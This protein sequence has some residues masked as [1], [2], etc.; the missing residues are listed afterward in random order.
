MFKKTKTTLLIII[1][2]VIVVTMAINLYM[3]T[4]TGKA[5]INSEIEKKTEAISTLNSNIIESYVAQTI[6]KDSS[7]ANFVALTYTQK[8]IDLYERVLIN[9]LESNGAAY[10]HFIAFEPYI[11]DESKEFVGPYVSLVNGEATISYDYSTSYYNYTNQEFYQ[12]TKE[13]RKPYISNAIYDD[14]SNKYMITVSTPIIDRQNNFIGCVSTDI[15]LTYLSVLIDRYN[16]NDSQMYIVDSEGNY[17][18]HSDFSKVKNGDNILN[19]IDPSFSNTAME[20]AKSEKGS[21]IYTEYGKDYVVYYNTLEDLGWKLI[22]V[23]D[24]ATINAPITLLKNK[25]IVISLISILL[26]S[27]SIIIII[28][29]RVE[30][31]IEMLLWEFDKI[32]KNIYSASIPENVLIRKDEFGIL[33]NSLA[34]MKTKL[35]DYQLDLEESLLQNVEF[36]EEAKLQNECLLQSESH[37]RDAINYIDSIFSAI[38]NLIYVFDKDGL[39]IDNRGTDS[40]NFASDQTLVGT[41]IL[42]F[43]LDEGLKKEVLCHIQ[44]VAGTNKVTEFKM[45]IIYNNRIF[46]Y[47]MRA[48]GCINNTAVI[49]G[50]DV[51]SLHNH[52]E[53]IEY[54]S[55]HDQLTG[56]YNRRY[57]EELLLPMVN[58]ENYPC[59]IISADV[60][61]L[62]LIN[63]SFGHIKGDELLLSFA[64][65]LFNSEIADENIVRVGGDEFFIVL[66]KTSK[67]VADKHLQKIKEDCKN[68]KINGID[69]SVSFGVG[70]ITRND[71][72]IEATIKDAEDIMYQNKMYD[73]PSRRAATIDVI[74]KTLAEKNPREQAHSNRVG[75]VC[76][77]FADKYGMSKTQQQVVKSSGVLHDIGKIGISEDLLNKEKEL[78]ERE[79]LEVKKH[80][81]IGFRILESAGNMKDIAQIVLA[82]HERWDGL[83]YPKGL[84]GEEIPIEARMVAIVDTYDAIVHTRTYRDGQT[85]ETSIE[86]LRRCSGTQFDPELVELFIDKVIPELL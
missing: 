13:T 19:E 81:D 84:K 65:V 55:Y 85:K 37:F 64:K 32:G 63:D 4:Q 57:F 74:S 49:V 73:A 82:H 26:L 41:H 76:E 53:K 43:A 45:N 50:N 2:P 71:K 1:I 9:T 77:I 67:E 28:N 15:D 34:D 6:A 33:A 7:V 17:L 42:D 51:T 14:I 60:N 80:P 78:T 38:P 27:F 58:E 75:K 18:T 3:S 69:L 8:N 44:D 83:G 46:N 12:V 23:T 20:I 70:E 11:F 79:F 22:F 59:C 66:P 16:T 54:L 61:G 24:E 5:I 29:R 52:I 56:L 35:K 21:A 10:G 25:Y 62:K 47:E 86:E 48:A 36:A 68:Y 39:C 40:E 72:S 30:K 31:P